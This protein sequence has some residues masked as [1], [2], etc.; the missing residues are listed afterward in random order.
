MISL[1]QQKARNADEGIRNHTAMHTSKKSQDNI[2][3]DYQEKDQ[4]YG[5]PEE[6]SNQE[7]LLGMSWNSNLASQECAP[8]KLS[9][10]I[11]P[12]VGRN[13]TSYRNLDELPQLDSR[14]LSD[15]EEN[16]LATQRYTEGSQ[17]EE[18]EQR[19]AF[20][21]TSDPAADMEVLQSEGQIAAPYSE[22]RSY[23]Y[24]ASTNNPS[25]RRIPSRNSSC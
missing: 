4:I 8:G 7:V 23:H 14:Q 1:K 17:R 25:I 5:R 24:R 21:R 11:S 20:N 19:A 9:K 13:S 2:E 16:V 12:I 3:N 10:V 6:S 15:G 22:R 18:V